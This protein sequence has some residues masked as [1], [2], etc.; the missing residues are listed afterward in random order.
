MHSWICIFFLVRDQ[1]GIYISYR[2]LLSS[3]LSTSKNYHQRTRKINA[4]LRVE[5]LAHKIKKKNKIQRSTVYDSILENWI[6]ITI[7]S[8]INLTNVPNDIPAIIGWRIASHDVSM[9]FSSWNQDLGNDEGFCIITV[10]DNRVSHHGTLVLERTS[11]LPPS[12]T[13]TSFPIRPRFVYKSKCPLR[14]SPGRL[15][16]QRF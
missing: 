16:S 9:N 5:N 4:N 8:L 15:V 14:R 1:A 10:A 6:L 11:N 2:T 12:S 3:L 7:E 13:W